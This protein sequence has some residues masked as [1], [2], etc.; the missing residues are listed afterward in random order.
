MGARNAT[1]R[2]RDVAAA[3]AALS[4]PARGR[5]A[6]LA[7]GLGAA[8]A[9]PACASPADG[10][11]EWRAVLDRIGPALPE[12]QPPAALPDEPAG[13]AA[14]T[15]PAAS[16]GAEQQAALTAERERAERLSADAAAASA[17]AD[18]LAARVAAAEEAPRRAD[19]TRQRDAETRRR[20]ALDLAAARAQ[21]ED[22]RRG[23]AEAES[24][25]AQ[26]VQRLAARESDAET[27]RSAWAAARDALVAERD[28]AIR[29]RDAAAGDRDAALR[30]RDA[31][32]RERDG[33]E[34]ALRSRPEARPAGVAAFDPALWPLPAPATA[35]VEATEPA[36]APAPP[37]A[38]G[39]AAAEDLDRL[40]GRAEALLARTDIAGARLLL[41][42][43]AESGDGR[44]AFRLA[45]TYDPAILATRFA[46][47]LKGD[48]ARAAALYRRAAE[49]GVDAAPPRGDAPRP[50]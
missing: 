49:A 45:Q 40:L 4:R 48:P 12:L 50:R 32:R 10:T 33:L 42:R 13:T 29:D 23:L 22:L 27:G 14:G 8:L 30:D 17:R 11:P 43:A 47:R 35:H 44:A 31:A 18:A 15:C 39:P 20:D 28:S 3:A 25:A 7:F 16:W 37:R 9:A 38:A 46:S 1:V 2:R 19:E 34:A 21:A 5:L 36:P 26:A 24:R 6:G 41:E